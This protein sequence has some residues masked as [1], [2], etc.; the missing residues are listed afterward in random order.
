MELYDK[1][2]EELLEQKSLAALVFLIEHGR[3]LEFSVYGHDF[4]LSA[5]NSEKHVS[6]WKKAEE[7]SF[8]SIYELISHATI[9]GK[10]FIDAWNDAELTTLF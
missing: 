9:S 8:D 10:T 1:I 7:Q 4:F 6:L 5:S 3:E 2:C